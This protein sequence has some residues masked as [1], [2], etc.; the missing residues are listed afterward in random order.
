MFVFCYYVAR[1]AS[2]Q[3]IAYEDTPF[4]DYGRGLALKTSVVRLGIEFGEPAVAA[5]AKALSPQVAT[6]ACV[7]ACMHA[8]VFARHGA[9]RRGV[10]RRSVAWRVPNA[11]S[12]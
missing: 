4:S 5:A 6:V 2:F 12:A 9:A 3:L 10:A 1:L 11:S 8:C 7:H